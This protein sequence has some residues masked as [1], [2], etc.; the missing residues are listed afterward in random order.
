MTYSQA[1]RDRNE[2]ERSVTHTLF[3]FMIVL[4]HR[5]ARPHSVESVSG[6]FPSKYTLRSTATMGTRSFV[7][8]WGLRP[9]VSRQ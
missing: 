9:C 5:L 7:T 2:R 3:P 6:P 4:R 8:A 1:Y